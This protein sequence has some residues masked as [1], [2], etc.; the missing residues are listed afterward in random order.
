[1]ELAAIGKNRVHEPR[2]I[3]DAVARFRVAEKIDERHMIGLR[4]GQG[5]DNEI[6]IR[7][8]EARPTIRLDHRGR[9]MS[10]SDAATQA[11]RSRLFGIGYFL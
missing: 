4:T 1:M 5:A 3:D 9:I 6:E 10:I 11:R 2:I 7:R 8:G